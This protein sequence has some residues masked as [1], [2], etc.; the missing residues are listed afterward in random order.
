[1]RSHSNVIPSLFLLPFSLLFLTKMP[2][3]VTIRRQGLVFGFQKD[4]LRT[5]LIQSA[6]ASIWAT[7]TTFHYSWQLILFSPDSWI[8]HVCCGNWKVIS[9]SCQMLPATDSSSIPSMFAEREEKNVSAGKVK[10]SIVDFFYLTTKL[11]KNSLIS[12]QTQLVHNR[13][14]ITS[15][16]EQHQIWNHFSNPWRAFPVLYTGFGWKVKFSTVAFFYLTTKLPDNL[17]ISFQTRSQHNR[18]GN[19]IKKHYS[20][21]RRAPRCTGFGC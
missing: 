5:N 20:N 6:T 19:Q 12:I 9:C 16:D 15:K 2:D 10:F 21:P 7:W 4:F 13:Q 11:P 18:R 1:M 8:H 14:G 17:L 3:V